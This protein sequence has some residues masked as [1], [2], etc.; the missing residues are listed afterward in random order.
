MV[1]SPPPPLYILEVLNQSILIQS[2]LL[3]SQRF[4]V[5]FAICDYEKK[6][7]AFEKMQVIWAVNVVKKFR[8]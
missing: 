6:K 3:K 1:L 4:A 7:K 5:W 2:F 8:F